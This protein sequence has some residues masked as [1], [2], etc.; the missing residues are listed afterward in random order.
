MGR[1]G[2]CGCKES[3]E[4]RASLEADEAERFYGELAGD[5]S[6]ESDAEGAAPAEADLFWAELTGVAPARGPR[7]LVEDAPAPLVPQ[8]AQFAP[9]ALPPPIASPPPVA[10]RPQ[11]AGCA[12]PPAAVVD[13]FAVDGATLDARQRAAVDAVAAQVVASQ[14]SATPVTTVCLVG[15]TDDTGDPAANLLLGSRR[16]EA[17]EREL[18]TALDRRSAGLSGRIAFRPTSVGE[19]SPL[20]PNTTPAGQARNRSVEILLGRGA[21][22]P[23]CHRPA[24]SAVDPAAL[25]TFAVGRRDFDAGTVT[26]VGRSVRLRGTVFYPASAAGNGTPFAPALSGRAP[27]VVMAHGNHG[28]FHS[29]ANRSIESCSGSNGFVPIPNHQGYDYFQEQLARMGVVAIS[30]DCGPTNCKGFT[31]TNIRERAEMIVRT[32]VHFE[33][34]DRT[35]VTFKQ[36]LDFRRVGLMGHSRGGEAVLVAA[37]ILAAPGAPVRATVQGV[38]SLAPTDAGA[39]TGRPNGYAFMAILPAADGDVVSNDGA[40]F[41]DQAVP[42]PFKCQLYVHGASHNLF[43]RQWVNNEGLGPAQL[44]R[45][46]HERILSAYGC[47]FYRQVLLAHPMLGFLRVDELPPAT[48]TDAVHVSFEQPGVTTVDDHENRNVG[49]NTLGQPTTQAAGLAA[50]E[51]DFSQNGARAF[52]A[53]FFGNTVGLV[54]TTTAAAGRYRSALGTARDLTGREVW[55][56]AAEVY[57]GTSV[58]AGPT[59]YRIGLEDDAGR[60]AFADAND[61]GGL[62]RP[63][64]RTA[65]D[66]AAIG[67]DFTKTMPKT[68]RFPATCFRGTF[69]VRRVRAVV[70][71]LDRNDGRAIAFDQLQIV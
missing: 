55:I 47:A 62:P 6:S 66:L 42:N 38:I 16:A 45:A 10:P 71:E 67:A 52:N 44:S 60:V 22:R 4:N 69:D 51:F 63:Y 49:L 18:R 57:D 32:L 65:F 59:G 43:N 19:G 48:R 70:V 13:A 24:V 25:G 30:V 15:H 17:T 7:A 28:L 61:A 14:A 46:E 54:A 34:L 29:P 40:K 5:G 8:V 23:P 39:S 37:A 64:D 3:G 9:V 33:G 36:R 26:V 1:T 53:T 27:M 68:Q 12:G 2:G 11:T 21:A 41:Y 20:A 56:R 50:D 31:A 35:D 58:P